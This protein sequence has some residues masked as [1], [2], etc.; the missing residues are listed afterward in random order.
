MS[1]VVLF[2][3]T[4]GF[5]F[6]GYLLPWNQLAFF[7]TR[8]GTDIAGA[9]P[10]IGEWMLRFLRG[11]D[12]VTGGSAS[13]STSNLTVRLA[14]ASGRGFGKCPDWV[15]VFWF[16]FGVPISWFFRQLVLEGQFWRR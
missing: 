5:G 9:V 3:L 13:I 4:L 6:T 8:V 11:G 16:V 1:G 10:I 12:Q 2:V 15:H 7:A 14:G